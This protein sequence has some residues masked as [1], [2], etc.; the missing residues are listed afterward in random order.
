M[1]NDLEKLFI[2]HTIERFDLEE[3]PLLSTQMIE[4][5]VWLF[6]QKHGKELYFVHM[7]QD[8]GG[9]G[10]ID[11]TEEG[12]WVVSSQGQLQ[13]IYGC[14]PS[15]AITVTINTTKPVEQVAITIVDKLFLVAM[16]SITSVTLVFRDSRGNLVQEID[17]HERPRDSFLIKLI[18]WF[19]MLP[20]KFKTL[21]SPDGMDE[22]Y[23]HEDPLAKWFKKKRR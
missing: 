4:S 11:I 17:Y 9:V 12:D 16:S 6:R 18:R 7:E 8:G 15:N 5:R 13:F 20:Y 14:L 23:L 2:E 22:V 3:T 10:T 19:L 1:K 21:F